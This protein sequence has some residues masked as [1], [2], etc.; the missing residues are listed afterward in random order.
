[1][2]S[3]S[4]GPRGYAP[5]RQRSLMCIPARLTSPSLLAALINQGAVLFMCYRGALTTRHVTTI[6]WRLIG[7]TG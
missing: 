6:M 7:A 3:D 4:V 5:K 1:M 2:R